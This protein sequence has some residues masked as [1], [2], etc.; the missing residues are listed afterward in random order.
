ME[1]WDEILNKITQKYNKATQAAKTK[2]VFKEEGF[3]KEDSKKS[4]DVVD[5]EMNT[6]SEIKASSST[7]S[8]YSMKKEDCTSI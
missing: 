8:S 7:S 5:D 6:R 1:E 4:K 3:K 2:R